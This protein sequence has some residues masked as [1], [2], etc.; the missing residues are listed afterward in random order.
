MK[1]KEIHDLTDDQLSD[2]LTTFSKE[3]F[4]LRFQKISGQLKN[5]ARFRVVRRTIAR[6]KTLQK[7]RATTAQQQPAQQQPAQQ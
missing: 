1:M 5:T 3:H 6:L 7:K 4:N 2:Q